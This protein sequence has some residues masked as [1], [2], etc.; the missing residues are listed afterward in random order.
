MPAGRPAPDRVSPMLRHVQRQQ[1]QRQV[2]CACAAAASSRGVARNHDVRVIHSHE[3]AR[4]RIPRRRERMGF[5]LNLIQ[6][7][8]GAA[9]RRACGPGS[10]TP[11]A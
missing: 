10:K 2:R 5:P 3:I 9:R 8:S 7:V 6:L 1:S 4:C 11:C